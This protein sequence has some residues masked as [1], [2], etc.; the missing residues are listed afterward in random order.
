MQTFGML[1]YLK[2]HF[3]EDFRQLCSAMMG[4]IIF[5]SQRGFMRSSFIQ[6][7]KIFSLLRRQLQGSRQRQDYL[8]FRL[9]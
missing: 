8:H 4:L 6:L 2:V 7:L 1:F 3:F 5:L 9:K